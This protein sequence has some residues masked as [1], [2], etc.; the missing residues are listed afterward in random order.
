[1]GFLPPVCRIATVI[2]YLSDVEEGGETLFPNARLP[3]MKTSSV[4]YCCYV[5]ART[6][7]RIVCSERFNLRL[8]PGNETRREGSGL[9]KNA[10]RRNRLHYFCGLDALMLHGGL[11]S[12]RQLRHIRTFIEYL[13]IR[14]PESS[15]TNPF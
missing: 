5:Q 6:R 1:M 12:L 15:H 13:V 7:S 4:R 3:G 8:T 14:R 9:F 10:V 11:E 2:M